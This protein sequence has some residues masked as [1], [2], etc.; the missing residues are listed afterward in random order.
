MRKKNPNGKRKYASGKLLHLHAEALVEMQ[1]APKQ[2]VTKPSN[3]T[4]KRTNE[5]RFL[6]IIALSLS[7]LWLNN[8]SF[9]AQILYDQRLIVLWTRVKVPINHL[10][11][12]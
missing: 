4:N 5:K 2:I 10:K 12:S 11:Q 3:N 7:M 8:F 1:K 9:S 6:D